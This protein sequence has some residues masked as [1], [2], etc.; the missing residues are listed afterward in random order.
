MA[1]RH[2]ASIKIALSGRS[3]PPGCARSGLVVLLLALLCGLGCDRKAAP[4]A[5]PVSVDTYTVR[6]IVVEL[7][8]PGNPRSAFRVRHEAIDEFKSIDGRLGMGAMTMEFR[9]DGGVLN[10]LVPGDKIEMV[11]QTW[12]TGEAPM[13]YLDNKVTRIRK[14]PQDTELEFRAA[15]PGGA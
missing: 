1:H 7:P 8:D 9:A 6:G 11:F 14:L 3:W 5:T 12:P 15:R 13:R 2:T 10:G 4:A